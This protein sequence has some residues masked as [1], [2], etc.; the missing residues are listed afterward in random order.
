MGCSIEP[1]CSGSF[2]ND[3]SL[4]VIALKPV[5]AFHGIVQLSHGIIKP[6]QLFLD[7]LGQ[8]LNMQRA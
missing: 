6:F 7:N 8:C 4:F 2:L 1:L 3:K 5:S